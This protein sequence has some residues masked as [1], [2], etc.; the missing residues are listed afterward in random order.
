M[1]WLIFHSRGSSFLYC[2]WLDWQVANLFSLFTEES[3][4]CHWRELAE[5]LRPPDQGAVPQ[6]V[7][8][9]AQPLAAGLELGAPDHLDPAALGEAPG[10]GP[11]EAGVPPGVPRDQG[12]PHGQH[13]HHD[14]PHR[15]QILRSLCPLAPMQV[16]SDIISFLIC[17]HLPF[18]DHISTED[19]DLVG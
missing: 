6:E 17:H 10:P 5:R 1:T 11:L 8:S 19:I 3:E 13:L 4:T 7:I 12:L 2:A 16:A 15:P 9:P 14:G 18:A